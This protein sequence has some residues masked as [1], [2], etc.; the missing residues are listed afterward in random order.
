MRFSAIWLLL[1]GIPLLQAPQNTGIKMTVRRDLGPTFSSEETTYWQG[2][3]KRTERR[4]SQGRMK[5]DGSQEEVYGPHIATII[6]CDSGQQLNLNLDAAEYDQAPYPPNQQA[7]KDLMALAAKMPQ[8]TTPPEPPTVRIETTTVDTGERNNILGH[9]A[10]RIVTTR[11]TIPLQGS[12]SIPQE[13]VTDGWYIDFDQWL[14]CEHWWPAGTKAHSFGSVGNASGQPVERPEFIDVGDAQTGFRLLEVTTLTATITLSDGT[15]KKTESK[16]G[17]QVTL[18][19]EGPLDPA[20]F[21]IPAGF[22]LV[23]HVDQNV[24]SPTLSSEMK[25]SWERFKARVASFFSL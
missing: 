13:A 8:V 10:R 16:S 14:P 9:K 22:R 19:Q 17:T 23:D 11:K 12:S 3:R 2:D 20:L 1:L 25:D 24:A 7:M 5:P 6:R 4:S 18:F 15:V 21:E